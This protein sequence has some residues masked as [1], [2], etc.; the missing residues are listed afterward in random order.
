[1]TRNVRYDQQPTLKQP[2]DNAQLAE[3]LARQLI[4]LALFATFN[5][6][7]DVTKIWLWLE[8]SRQDMAARNSCFLVLVFFG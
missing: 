6:I 2:T 8:P 7:A 5:Q 4:L 3:V 1:L